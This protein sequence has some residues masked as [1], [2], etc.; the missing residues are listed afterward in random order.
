[1]AEVESESE[2]ESVQDKELFISYGREPELLEFVAR[3]KQD[4][5]SN[6]FSV[7]LDMKVSEFTVLDQLEQKLCLS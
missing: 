3:L 1:M 6:G 2:L 4:L 7:W 5:E